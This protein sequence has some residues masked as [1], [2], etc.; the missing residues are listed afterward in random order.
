MASGF[1]EEGDNFRQQLLEI[2]NGLGKEELEKL[3]FLCENCTPGLSSLNITSGL[4][5][6]RE[7]QNCNKIGPGNVR[8]LKW[9][10]YAIKRNDLASKLADKKET[11]KDSSVQINQSDQQVNSPIQETTPQKILD[12]DIIDELLSQESPPMRILLLSDKWQAWGESIPVINREM[13]CALAQTGHQVACLVLKAT[14]VEIEEARSHNVNLFTCDDDNNIYKGKIQS[15]YHH[16]TFPFEP[17]LVVGHG[18]LTGPL[19]DHFAS[20]FSCPRVHVFH[21]VPDEGETFDDQSMEE[22]DEVTLAKSAD[23]TAAIGVYLKDKWNSVLNKEVFEIIPG[24]P[25]YATARNSIA[26]PQCR[27]FVATNPNAP[28]SSGLDIA[29]WALNN[30]RRSKLKYKATLIVRNTNPSRTGEVEKKVLKILEQHDKEGV[31]LNFKK[32]SDSRQ[33]LVD[34]QGSTMFLLPARRSPFGVAAL[35]AIA[36]GIPVLI[37]SQSGLAYLIRQYFDEKYHSCILD[38]KGTEDQ[39]KAEDA[40]SWARAV[41]DLFEDREHAFLFASDFKSQWE[42]A[43]SWKSTMEVFMAKLSKSVERR[44]VSPTSFNKTAV[45]RISEED[46]QLVEEMCLFDKRQKFILFLSPENTKEMQEAVY[47]AQ[48]R[49]AAVFDFD[50]NTEETGFLAA[51]ERYLETMGKPACRMLPKE[52]EPISIPNGTPWILVEGNSAIQ[53]NPKSKINCWISKFFEQLMKKHSQTITFVLVWRSDPKMK[54]LCKKVRDIF[55]IA[56]ACEAFKDSK[57]FILSTSPETDGRIDDI[58]D[59]W[60]TEIKHTTV[61]GFCGAIFNDAI[62]KP[63]NLQDPDFSLPT[64]EGMKVL[65]TWLRWVDSEMAVLYSSI[66][67]SPEMG[68]DDAN[69]FYRGGRISW[70]AIEMNYAVERE[71]WERLK[72]EIKEKVKYSGA[73]RLVFSHQ[74]GTGGTTSSRKILYDL[75]N[76]FPCVCLKAI[77]THTREA[78]TQLWRF[79]RRPVI[80]L[81]DVKQSPG[82]EYEIDML[83]DSLSDER[84]SC[85]IIQV[86]HRYTSLRGKVEFQE[87]KVKPGNKHTVADTLTSLEADCFVEVYSTQNK[88]RA[89]NLRHHRQEKKELQIPFYYA[90]VAFEQRFE[91]LRPFVADC[92]AGL[93]K[94]QESVLVFMAMAHYYAQT[95]L[96]GPQFARALGIS[97]RACHNLEDFLPEKILDLL[98]E[99]DG[100]WYCRHNLISKEILRQLLSRPYG[101]NEEN[102]K[103]KLAEKA[104]DFVKHMDE[105]TCS[106]MLI[107]RDD[108]HAKNFFSALVMDIPVDEDV[109]KVFEETIAVFPTNPYFKVHLG[110]Y[111]SKTMK[112]GF[113][114]AIKYTNE[115]I[116]CAADYRSHVRSRFTQM[117]GMVYK[118]HVQN[119]IYD[120]SS[121]L[122]DI[123]SYAEKGIASFKRA[124]SIC[125]ELCEENYIP[126]VAMMCQIFKHV[127]K[128][129]GGLAEYL[130]SSS[131]Q[132][133]K[134]L[135]DSLLETADDLEMVSESDQYPHWRRQLYSFQ[136]GKHKGKSC[137]LLKLFKDFKESGK[138][139][140]PSVNREIVR[141][142]VDLCSEKGVPLEREAEE[143]IRLLDES[144][145]HRSRIDSTMR[146]WMK[147]APHVPVE[148]HVAEA[149]VGVWCS[150][151]KSVWSCFYSYIFSCMR[152]LDG[153]KHYYDEA[154]RNSHEDLLVA[155]RNMRRYDVGRIRQPDRPILFL[156]DGKGM[157]KLVTL[158]AQSWDVRKSR[159]IDMK[160]LDKLHRYEGVINKTDKTSKNVGEIL[161]SCDLAVSFR[162]DLCEPP[163]VG[164]SNLYKKVHFYMAFNFFGTEAYNVRLIAQ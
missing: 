144:L 124:V 35:D 87:P 138:A 107:I 139:S 90:L 110:R 161:M 135:L 51:C 69:H 54:N 94:K 120:P 113:K 48:V 137:E 26:S 67:I 156:G 73:S 25:S 118:R 129:Q 150:N 108:D 92:L 34:I 133:S 77:N 136:M 143:M 45:P 103:N 153:G 65:P 148:I 15:M 60:K 142:W 12:E 16:E 42:K 62:S 157:K 57:V 123:I 88:E 141:V 102:W 64:D 71:S 27:C 18:T 78:I 68:K 59:D 104:I 24:L 13:S 115:G 98:I 17:D 56:S 55:C 40:D 97:K 44:P 86:A 81:V 63:N 100:S 114:D 28:D 22:C 140:I 119:L 82:E 37:S 127:D 85:L 7:L 14:A 9:Q 41:S 36:T 99:E 30:C 46:K 5:L 49:W 131:S 52:G 10:L 66:G 50:V 3:I 2:D 70:Y 152:I 33:E 21:C 79:C 163:L 101:I 84:V 4:G 122:A 112:N 76:D 149:K 132:E 125:Q 75:R 96:P 130:R 105:K 19:A 126:L 74:R 61:E 47:L 145:K 43:F 29:V 38:V 31:E 83:F 151:D 93:T 155:V 164:E 1:S 128:T 23:F 111:Y 11:F 109:V 134:F 72:T 8:F 6:F 53:A 162:P 80:V 106:E 20:R 160:Y 116:Q 39:E 117:K 154:M 158:D 121:K 159:S 95:T 32:A 146:L 91:G 58:A 89:G 147:I